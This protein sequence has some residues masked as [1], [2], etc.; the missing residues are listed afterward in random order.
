MGENWKTPT[1]S[2]T[3]ILKQWV[4]HSVDDPDSIM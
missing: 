1:A 3:G 4:E 2:D